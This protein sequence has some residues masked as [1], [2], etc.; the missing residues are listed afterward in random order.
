MEN[1]KKENF[2]CYKKDK[3][4]YCVLNKEN[5][6]IFEIDK[7]GKEL[8]D[9]VLKLNGISKVK[10]KMNKSK[11]FLELEE[12]DIKQ[13]VENITNNNSTNPDETNRKIF[14]LQ[15]HLTGV[16]NLKC[17][18]CYQEE[19]SSKND[20]SLEEQKQIVDNYFDYIEKY[21]M[22]PEISLTGG[23]PIS[24]KYL[25]DLLTYIKERKSETRLFLLTNGTLINDEIIKKLKKINITRVQISL[26]GYNA[27]T[28]D[29]IRGKGNFDKAIE[30][31]KKLKANKI[32]TSVHCVIM[33]SNIND[34]E[35]YV[36]L[37]SE[38]N[39]DRLT[40]SRFVPIGNG[41]KNNV[42]ILSPEMIKK[43]YYQ[44]YELK[45]KYP[46]A[47]INLER[48]LW[49]IINPEFGSTCPVGE[50]TITILNDGVVLPCRRLPIK[51]GNALQ[52]SIAEIMFKSKILNKMHENNLKECL[53]CKLN[54][55]CKGGCQ[56]IAFAYF[57]KLMEKA[58]PECWIA[59]E[60][61]PNAKQDF[62]KVRY[63]ERQGYFEYNEET[64]N[65]KNLY[66]DKSENS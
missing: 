21:C 14:H 3:E 6:A 18:H 38:L 31:I 61:L 42:K 39:I 51:I 28:H 50:G 65:F 57:G 32:Y 41:N 19:Y 16:C 22:Q 11:N 58:D 62:K 53:G 10:M 12:N 46:K 2:Y 27:L 60:N 43:I 24:Y 66:A 40:F 15:W 59:N 7:E 4:T 64:T 34:I 17:K 54:K 52:E 44:I 37:C 26:D 25:F 56:G 9:N 1:I 29:T 47:N 48:D 55:Q 23:E 5:G 49:M 45:M 35:K 30:A 13:F 8:L 33:E 63:D 20:L 36:Q